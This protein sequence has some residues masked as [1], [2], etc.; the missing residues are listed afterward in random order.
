MAVNE[1]V[2]VAEFEVEVEVE[3]EGILI[4]PK[5]PQSI[6]REISS[7]CG[8]KGEEWRKRKEKSTRRRCKK[9]KGRKSKKSKGEK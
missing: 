7:S 2:S 6:A 1:V 9:Q 4:P 8:H 3:V 5:R